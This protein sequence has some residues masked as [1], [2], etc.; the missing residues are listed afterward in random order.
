MSILRLLA[1]S[2]ALLLVGFSCLAEKSRTKAMCKV[3]LYRGPGPAFIAVTNSENGYEYAFDTGVVG[4]IGETDAQVRCV[5]DG[6]KVHN[7]EFWQHLPL[8]ETETVFESE[9][10]RLTGRLIEPI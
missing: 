4:R 3:G 2:T 9:G 10:V 8:R 5:T 1:L 7:A 6:L